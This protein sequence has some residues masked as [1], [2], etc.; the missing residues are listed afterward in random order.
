MLLL[1]G[2]MQQW[3]SML[4]QAV[5]PSTGLGI[6]MANA[7]SH[8]SILILQS[9][10]ITL[11]LRKDSGMS[12][13]QILSYSAGSSETPNSRN[14]KI[15]LMHSNSCLRRAA[16]S[17]L[18]NQHPVCPQSNKT[19]GKKNRQVRNKT[20]CG[21]KSLGFLAHAILQLS[22]QVWEHHLHSKPPR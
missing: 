9:L 13:M 17:F 20:G 7:G 18:K 10:D 12:E 19:L 14:E 11:M 3:C 2:Q 6:H 4:F 8:E 22:L 16:L 21:S 15:P 5:S 1:L